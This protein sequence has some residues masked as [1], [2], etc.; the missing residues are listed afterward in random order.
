MLNLHFRKYRSGDAKRAMQ[1]LS[2][3]PRLY[4]T[5]Q[6][7]LSLKLDE[8]RDR[9]AKAIWALS[10]HHFAGLI[11]ETPKGR[12][13]RKVSTIYVDPLFRGQ[14][15]GSRLLQHCHESWIMNGVRSAHVTANDQVALTIQPLLTRFGFM[16][17]ECQWERYKKDSFE[18]VYATKIQ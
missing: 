2:D 4:P 16:K 14:R 3:L 6:I 1:M 18:F 12:Y 10:N 15:V 11:I 13:H 17:I 7:W 9:R 5:S 8:I